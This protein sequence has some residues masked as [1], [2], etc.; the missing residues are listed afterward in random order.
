VQTILII[1]DEAESR[2]LLTAILSESGYNVLAADGGE[3]ALA[4]IAQTRP[5]LILLD[6]RMPGLD[7]FEVCRRFK[8][9][10]DTQ[11][12]PVMFITASAALEEKVDGFRLGA[13][14]YITKPFQREELLARVRTHLELGRLRAQ[15]EEQ[16]ATRTTQLRESEQRVRNMAVR[17][18][19]AQEE[20][21]RRIAGELHDDLSQKLAVL[22]LLVSGLK[23]ET[24]DCADKRQVRLT[25]V[26]EG[27]IDLHGTIRVL[28]H[29]LHPGVVERAGLGEA[30]KLHCREF[31]RITGTPVTLEVTGASRELDLPVALSLFRVAQE[32]LNNVRKHA[33]ATHVTIR[34]SIN[35]SGTELTIID[36]GSGFDPSEINPNEGLGLTSIEERVRFLGG[37]IR[38]KSTVGDGTTIQARVPNRQRGA[39]AFGDKPSA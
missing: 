29:K 37:C 20:E 27:L 9:R 10:P 33:A 2:V 8:S 14:D 13:V 23:R 3:L 30:L 19:N 7:G 24:D 22:G 11:E 36:N 16:V 39:T 17:L 21:R 1:E 15:L 28:A 6:I 31:S 26:Q 12:I 35:E 5:E 18:I 25:E 34:A 4:T 38:I 32:A